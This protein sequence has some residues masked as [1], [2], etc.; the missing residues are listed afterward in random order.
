[1]ALSADEAYVHK[2]CKVLTGLLDTAGLVDEE[3]N[4]DEA[5]AEAEQV[6]ELREAGQVY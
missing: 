1:M 3:D 6:D 2:H 4:E 5:M